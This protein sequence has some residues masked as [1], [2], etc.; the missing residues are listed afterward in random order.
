M[1]VGKSKAGGAEVRRADREPTWASQERPRYQVEVELAPIPTILRR[2]GIEPADVACAWIDVQG[3]EAKILR[4]GEALWRQGVFV[5]T[6]LWPFGL[7]HQGGDEAF[8]AL[9]ERHF[10]TFVDIR[11]AGARDTDLKP[12]TALAELFVNS[13][14][15]WYTDVLLIPE[16][17]TRA[18]VPGMS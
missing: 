17:A 3:F 2:Y 4:S 14:P 11:A 18:Q 9:A 5:H 1:V 7:R 10:A 12:I 6:E 8:L 15:E 13:D 16:Q